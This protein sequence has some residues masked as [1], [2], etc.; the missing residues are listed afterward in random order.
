MLR[1]TG[2][3]SYSHQFMKTVV[4]RKVSMLR[5]PSLSKT[6]VLLRSCVF[7]GS[8]LGTPMKVSEECL[9]L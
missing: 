1:T 5:T 4:F 2:V 3:L 8:G 9:V 6:V 7:C